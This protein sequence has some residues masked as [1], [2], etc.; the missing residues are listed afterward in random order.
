M[1]GNK[2]I[3]QILIFANVAI[4]VALMG[5]VIFAHK[6]IKRAPTN[7]SEELNNLEQN[8]AQSLEIIPIKMAKNTF[9]IYQE[10]LSRMRYLSLEINILPMKETYRPHLIDAEAIINDTLIAVAGTM[11]PDDL[12]SVT[13]KIILE[14]RL[15]EAI[16]LKLNSQGV[17]KIFFSRFIIQ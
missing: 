6:G 17:K 1:T 7:I 14:S 9:N 10:H 13:G 2:K 12:S 3:D 4:M 16:N 15:R 11:D 5:V 8:S